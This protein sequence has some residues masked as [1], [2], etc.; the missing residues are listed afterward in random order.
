MLFKCV[1]TRNVRYLQWNFLFDLPAFHGQ[2]HHHVVRL[3]VLQSMVKHLPGLSEYGENGI[4]DCYAMVLLL[5]GD[6]KPVATAQS[7]TI[8]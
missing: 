6:D 4:C 5:V 7:A 3:R 1:Q 2:Y 8:P